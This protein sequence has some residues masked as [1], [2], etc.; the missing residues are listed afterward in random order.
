[1]L[2]YEHGGDREECAMMRKESK[3]CERKQA[4]SMV[5]ASKEEITQQGRTRLLSFHSWT[6]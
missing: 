1:M 2:K 5:Q 3:E 6:T 4:Q